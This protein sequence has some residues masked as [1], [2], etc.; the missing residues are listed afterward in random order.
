M[1]SEEDKK[2]LARQ[3]REATIKAMKEGNDYRTKVVPPASLYKR[4][5]K[6]VPRAV[7]EWEEVDF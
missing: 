3:R 4:K 5:P 7:E 2:I 6:Y 1:I